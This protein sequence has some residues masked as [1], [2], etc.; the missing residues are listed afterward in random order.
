MMNKP[1]WLLAKAIGAGAGPHYKMLKD[2]EHFELLV[3]LSALPGVRPFKHRD[4]TDGNEIHGT[5][6]YADTGFGGYVVIDAPFAKVKE[7]LGA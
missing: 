7:K 4:I 6:I 5:A 3:N 1:Q 2:S